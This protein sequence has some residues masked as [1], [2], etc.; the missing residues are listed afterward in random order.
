ME[1]RRMIKQ[2]SL[3]LT[4]GLLAA[5]VTAASAAA[6]QSAGASANVSQPPRDMLNLT[7]RQRN[8]AWSDLQSRATEQKVPSSFHGIVGA[9]VPNGV[10]LKPMPTKAASDVPSL[11]DY[12]FA[13]TGGKLL[14]VNPR[15]KKV[16]AVMS[17]VTGT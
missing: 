7:I 4:A 11:K 8:T 2:T 16:A 5:G 17:D 14:I 12:D 13:M 10:K 3:A 6:M 9:I 15:D 1:Y